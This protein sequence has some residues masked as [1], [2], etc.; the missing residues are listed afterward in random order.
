LVS[1]PRLT[2]RWA[3]AG[4]NSTTLT[5]KP[6]RGQT[7]SLT[8]VRIESAFIAEQLEVEPVTHTLN[9]RNSYQNYI[10]VP[11]LPIRHDLG[12]LCRID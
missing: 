4:Q 7:I 8:P 1:R 2:A 6:F 12:R 9:V 3:A 10:K 11:R 5:G